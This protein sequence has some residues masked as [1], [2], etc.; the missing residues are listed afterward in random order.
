MCACDCLPAHM[1]DVRMDPAHARC[2]D[3]GT[4]LKGRPNV[5]PVCG[6]SP[7]AEAFA[8][9]AI[10]FVHLGQANSRRFSSHMLRAPATVGLAVAA[11]K[12]LC[13]SIGARFTTGQW[14]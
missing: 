5:G 3:T 9:P 8:H 14:P 4:Y 11:D 2:M 6:C 10:G 12:Y 13:D 7:E 1:Q